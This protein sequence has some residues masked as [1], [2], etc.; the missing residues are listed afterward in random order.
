MNILRSGATADIYDAVEGRKMSITAYCCNCDHQLSRSVMLDD[1]LKWED[2]ALSQEAFPEVP[3]HWREFLFLS[4][5]CPNCF[6]ELLGVDNDDEDV[7]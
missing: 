1:Y 5:L 2:G 4:G 7:S 6:D 3:P